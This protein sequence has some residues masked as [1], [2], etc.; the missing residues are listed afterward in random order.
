[1]RPAWIDA[2][3]AA[4]VREAARDWK[5][6]GA[7]DA[8]ALAAIE[9]EYP[10]SRLELA[11]AWKV[12]VFV[13]VSVAVL[14]V[15]IG[16]FGFEGEGS[17]R[18]FAYSAIL[19]AA[20]EVL[21]G[22]R[23][24]GTGSDAATSFWAVIFLII[25]FGVLL[26]AE[27]SRGALTTTLAVAAV[28]WAAACWRW[29]FALYGAFAGVAGF[30]FLARFP[31]ERLG[32]GVVGTALGALSLWLT[33]RPRLPPSR[34][35][36]FAGVFVVSALALYGAINLYSR[37][38]RLVERIGS[39]ARALR[40]TEAPPGARFFFAAGTALVP[41]VLIVWGLRA[42]RKL[43][44]DTGALIAALSFLTLY[45]YVRFG[46]LPI[47]AFGLSLIGVA[48]WLNRRLARAPGEE[49]RGFTASSRLSAE[50]EAA[51]PAAALVGAAA[52]PISMPHSERG[53]SPGGGR[54]GGGGASGSI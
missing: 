31:L 48:L 7:I 19:A 16:V 38:E 49:T 35:R 27:R 11:R 36:A 39:G 6:A 52:A 24:G 5:E 47:I 18:F 9:A 32:W 25:G 43:V 21:R 50:S 44:L 10:Q 45:H 2:D 46:S 51:G 15:Q 13:L 4:E 26:Q 23:L 20:T 3:R 17:G 8:A 22:S 42:R 53:F 29:G 33:E 54:S 30:F 37:D 28:A 14:G 12:L 1:V 34:R 40:V 41:I